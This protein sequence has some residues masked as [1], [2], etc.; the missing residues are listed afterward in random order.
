[1][2]LF[3]SFLS[4]IIRQKTIK[5]TDEELKQIR[6]RK[7][8]L[9]FDQHNTIQVASTLPGRRITVEEGLN[10]FLTTMFWGKE[11]NDGFVLISTEPQLHRPNDDLGTITYFKYLEKK[12][13]DRVELKKRTCRFV[14]EE[15]G[16]KFREFFGLYLTSLIYKSELNDDD[17]E[18]DQS[19]YDNVNYHNNYVTKNQKLPPNTIPADDPDNKALYHYILPDFIDMIRRLQQENINFS[20]ILRT[21]GIDSD[22]FLETIRPI[23]EGKHRDFPDIKPMKINSSI[24]NIRRD[25]N[26][27]FEFEIDNQIFKDEISIH[28]KLNSLEGINAIRDDFGFWQKNKS[29][30]YCAKPL[31]I[32]L[33]DQECHHILFDD[34]IR[35]DSSDD[36]IVN[37]RLYNSA[38]SQYENVDF[39]SY[40][41]FA[42]SNIIQPNLINLL[43]PHIKRNSTTNY[44]YEMIKKAQLVYAKLLEYKDE[45]TA[46]RP[47]SP[48]NR[49]DFEESHLNSS[50][51]S[52]K[53][54]AEFSNS[55]ISR[56]PNSDN[57]NNKNSFVR[58]N[59][60]ISKQ[61]NQMEREIE[62]LIIR[63]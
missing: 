10:N 24:G 39:D 29:E 37:I 15:P 43:N 19:E 55:T 12:I 38:L 23:M 62:S 30:C 25:I 63:M 57:R 13:V 44:F 41:T 20:I 48:K 18:N 35:L 4:Q 3:K 52:I 56:E 58:I 6:K 7:L 53:K 22:S 50:T 60:E 45:L 2:V 27:K 61:I 11:V 8:I 14:F 28:Q 46:P 33:D 31:W 36:C 54:S 21:M 34:N 40:S 5:F 51:E 16:C 1:L 47:A 32:N 17:Y 9:H 59:K 49:L 26:E 42:K